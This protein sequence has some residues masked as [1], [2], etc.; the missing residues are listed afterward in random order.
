MIVKDQECRFCIL[1]TDKPAI[2]E[3]I[4]IKNEGSRGN[5]NK[6]ISRAYLGKATGKK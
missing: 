5:K 1:N 6:I 4:Q 3:K 2:K